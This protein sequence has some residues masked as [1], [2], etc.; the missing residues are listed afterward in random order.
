MIHTTP[1]SVYSPPK[2]CVETQGPR[3][4]PRKAGR[5]IKTFATLLFLLLFGTTAHRAFA[6]EMVKGE[7][8]SVGIGGINGKDGVYRAGAWVPVRV[9]L[10]NRSGKQLVCRLAVEQVDLDGDKVLSL[11]PQ[12]IL[13]AADVNPRDSWLYYWPKPDD[14]DLHGVKSVVVLDDSGTQVLAT[15]STLTSLGGGGEARGIN[16]RDDTNNRSSRFVLLLGPNQVG[17]P[18]YNGSYGGTE[19]VISA[20]AQ[21]ST[22]LPDQVLGLDG[23]DTIIWEADQLHASE[24]PPDFQLKAILDWVRAGGHLI[25]SVAAQGQDFLK[26]GDRLRD[27]MPMTFTG[28]RELKLDDLH[29]FPGA[30]NLI[31][32]GSPIMQVT[33]AVRADAQSDR[34]GGGAGESSGESSFGGH[35]HLRARR[36]HGADGGH[37]E[38]GNGAASI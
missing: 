34:G 6:A 17:F 24:L 30:G 19:N 38:P 37:H 23:V 29:T 7:I 18:S 8:V 22:D 14:D 31:G 10:E 32:D 33:G 13:D 11:G 28:V 9:R 16:A 20:W 1:Y 26:S 25:I 36:G 27:A 5:T 21:Q 3:A 4:W 35:R 2:P 12:I 15:L